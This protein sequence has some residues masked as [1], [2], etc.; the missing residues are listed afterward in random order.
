MATFTQLH[1]TPLTT[2]VA[3][4]SWCPTMDLCAVVTTD[5]QLQIHRLNWQVLWVTSPDQL[6]T[7]ICWRPD[8]KVLAAGHTNGSMTLFNI[9]AGQV[10]LKTQLSSKPWDCLAWAEQA[11]PA[12]SSTKPSSSSSAAGTDSEQHSYQQRF[13]RL[14]EPPPDP[15]P[16]PATPASST[17]PAPDAAGSSKQGNS[18]GASASWPPVAPTLNILAGISSDG[19]MVMS[20]FGEAHLAEVPRAASAT[21]AAAAAAGGS[22]GAAGGS[23]TI[24]AQQLALTPDLRHALVLEKC[25][26]CSSGEGVTADMV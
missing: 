10:L 18:G 20:A 1:D 25:S 3:L 21:A 9:E 23:E 19:K 16:L 12:S 2:D 22:A 24:Q 4:A 11:A 17:T 15:V 13:Q 6:I 14:F 26:T 8:G 7:S 5:G